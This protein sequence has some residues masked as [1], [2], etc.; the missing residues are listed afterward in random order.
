MPAVYAAA[1]I[2]D[3]RGRFLCVKHERVGAWV[4]PG[5]KIESGETYARAVVRECSEELGVGVRFVRLIQAFRHDVHGQ[6]WLGFYCR[7]F[8][9][10]Y[11]SI[12][13]PHKHAGLAWFSLAEMWALDMHPETEVAEAMCS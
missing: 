8:I 7:C 11:P 2:Q 4:F 9:D 12:A 6:E 13:E 10:G 1:V 3:A 5:G